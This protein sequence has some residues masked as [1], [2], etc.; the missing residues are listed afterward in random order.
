[1]LWG[2]PSCK[3]ANC[4]VFG[5]WLIPCN[6]KFDW[7]ISL[8]SSLSTPQISLF[9]IHHVG[10]G[11]QILI[12]GRFLSDWLPLDDCAMVYIS[13][14]EHWKFPFKLD[15]QCNILMIVRSRMEPRESQ[16]CQQQHKKTLGI[17]LVSCLLS[18][19]NSNWWPSEEGESVFW[20]SSN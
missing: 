17:Y 19:L 7:F 2:L 11:K 18:S 15:N 5:D 9:H 16:A 3:L 4:Q 8:I 6:T 10:T 20:N 13:E 14:V 12:N 1:M